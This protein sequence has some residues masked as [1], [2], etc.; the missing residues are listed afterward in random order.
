MALEARRFFLD[1]QARAFVSSPDSTLPASDPAWFEEDIESIELY[2]LKPTQN[3]NQPYEYL[4]LSGATVKFAVGTTTPAALQTS[5]SALSTAVS[6]SVTSLVTGGAGTSEIQKLTLSGPTAT[7][8]GFALQFPSRNVTVSSVSAGVFTAQNHGLYNGGSVT[9]TA[10][11]I[12]GG[13]FTNGA[14]YV[15]VDSTKDTFSISTAANGSAIVAAV[16]SGGGTAEVPAI[17]TPQISYAATASDVQ[18]AIVAAGLADNAAPQI[19][20]TGIPRKEFVFVYGGRSSGRDYANLSV[21]GSTLAGPKGVGANVS[22]NTAEIAALVAAGTSSVNLEVE[23]SEGAV[24]Q[25]F[26]RAATLSSDIIVTSGGTTP[27]GIG[28]TS[29]TIKSPDGSSWVVTMTN[30][31][32]LEWTKTP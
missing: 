21:V 8:G 25:T 31:G 29:F 3:P 16:T 15:V 10:F 17:T 20:V 22:F 28:L 6:S 32:N 13:T 7:E 5:W 11:T 1:V 24:R 26:R 23:I 12:S 14:T 4:D 19:A 27:V 30:D 18:A 9:L 2:A